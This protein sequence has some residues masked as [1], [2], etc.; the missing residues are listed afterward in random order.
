MVI[1][2]GLVTMS[3]PQPNQAQGLIGNVANENEVSQTGTDNDSSA[4]QIIPGPPGVIRGMA[5]G[6]LAFGIVAFLDDIPPIIDPRTGDVVGTPRQT[7]IIATVS[8]FT[9]SQDLLSLRL[10]QDRNVSLN[11]AFPGDG[12][13]N[14]SADAAALALGLPY[15]L[16][17]FTIAQPS[18]LDLLLLTT[19]G[20]LIDGSFDA[21]GNGLCLLPW[22]FGAPPPFCDLNFANTTETITN[23]SLPRGR[24]IV[25][26]D[27]FNTNSVFLLTVTPDQQILTNDLVQA[28]DSA[29]NEPYTLR[30]GIL[31]GGG[32]PGEGI[33]PVK[34]EVKFLGSFKP[35]HQI[36]GAAG[37]YQMV[38]VLK[39]GRYTFN[40]AVGRAQTKEGHLFLLRQGETS[41]QWIPV[42][43][44]SVVQKGLESLANVD[45]PAGRYM[46]AM[47]QVGLKSLTKKHNYIVTA[48]DETGEV[49]GMQI[50]EVFDIQ[51]MR[52]RLQLIKD[53]IKVPD[54]K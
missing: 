44:S 31:G 47:N 34:G 9:D 43:Q 15:N 18:D 45:L 30:I 37:E 49:V 11:L 29:T 8:A 7:Q 33:R 51:A 19:S 46:L 12:Y 27:Q 17:P 32:Q 48:L 5:E 36:S 10:T 2:L 26:V 53:S 25:D 14:L 42:A 28:W 16:F 38:D 23:V 1:A 4:F 35:V 22:A 39:S 40:V 21:E 41:K 6:G 52:D 3:L 20:A 50:S 24:Y 13:H 54:P